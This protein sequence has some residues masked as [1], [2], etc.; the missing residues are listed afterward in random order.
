[1]DTLINFLIDW[2]YWGM[3]IAAF[4]AGTVFPFSSE[5]ILLGLLYPSLGLNATICVIIATIGNSLGG[6]TCYYIGRV[7]N[8]D[9]IYK[10]FKVPEAKLRRMKIILYKR[11]GFIAF[12]AFLPGIGTI[13][14]IT[15]GLIRSH[16]G[17][18]TISMVLGKLMRYI[19]IALFAKGV[20]S[21]LV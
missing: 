11:S 15:L 4:L 17:V 7:G 9:W 8:M 12:F 6:L 5:T 14:A 1:M 3:F 13:I 10:L 19:L 20:F 2:G 21:Y 16:L 18:V